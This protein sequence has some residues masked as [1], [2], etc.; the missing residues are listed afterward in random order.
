MMPPAEKAP[1]PGSGRTVPPPGSIRRELLF[2]TSVLFLTAILVAVASAGL[3]VP[4]APSTLSALIAMTLIVL[5]ELGILYLYLRTLMDRT[6]LRPVD[7]IVVHA[8]RIAD[9][10]LKHR[11]P[12]EASEELD[13]I[14]DAVNS[15]AGR[16]IREQELL[17]T[18]VRS[19]NDTNRELTATTAELVRAAR[20]ASVGTLA[21]GVAHEIGNPLGA[22]R[23]Y[24]DVIRNRAEDPEQVRRIL[25]SA[26]SEVERIDA[27]IRH[28]LDFGRPT[29]R[30]GALPRSDA[31]EAVERVVEVLVGRG[32]LE[33]EWV[34]VRAEA[35]LPRVRAHSQHLDRILINLLQNA[36]QATAPG[37][38]PAVDVVLQAVAAQRE[39]VARRTDDPPTLDY[40][41]RRRL[42]DLLRV[43]A[44][45]P[46]DAGDRDV[47]LVVEDRGEGIP[48]EVLPL[49][50]DPFFTSREPGKG[51]G[52]GLA[53]TARI[54]GELGGTIEAGNRE[55]G[56]ARFRV[57]LPGVEMGD[58]AG[59]PAGSPAPPRT[60]REGRE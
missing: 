7:R 16:L 41:H 24:L 35:G 31:G 55:D 39:P 30:T 49:V 14:V 12:S 58:E 34:R 54:V 46:P 26:G 59:G 51:I 36:V 17:A 48:P 37:A 8:E 23:G 11:I 21:A 38:V 45:A 18:N 32:E 20:L 5:A 56:G 60:Q 42:G 13:R 9:G 19:L 3:V 6:V 15:L 53:L 22:L 50:F 52:M 33:R 43:R 47:M 2:S 4:L 1:R 28:I 10:E 57:R 25:T 27:I 40:S 29:V 44:P